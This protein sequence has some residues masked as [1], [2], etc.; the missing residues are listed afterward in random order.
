MVL[1]FR[2]DP[3]KGDVVIVANERAKRPEV[4]G[5]A[6]CPFCKGAENTT[7]PTTFALPSEGD[8]KVRTFRNLFAVLKP[9]GKFTPNEGGESFWRSQGVGD[10]EIIVETETHG[11]L[12]QEFSYD[13]LSMVFKAYKNR[14]VELSAREGVRCTFLFK[15]H[16]RLAGASID[17]EHSQIIALPFIPPIIQREIDRAEDHRQK[18]GDCL[19]CDLLSR[20]KENTLFENNSFTAICPSFSRFPFEIWI[21]PKE[22]KNTL[23][24]F[25][26]DEGLEF[27]RL[28]QDCVKALSKVSK[29]YNVVYH[30]APDGTDLHFHAEIYPRANVWAGIELGTGLLVNI[31]TE[32]EALAA[33]K[34][35]E[36]Y[37][38]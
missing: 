26:N 9:E 1:E 5:T 21:I 32:K 19:Y 2:E 8:W 28:L 37:G 31:K 4:F 7:P 13:E 22:H 10:H 29:D 15:N 34:K 30:S 6:L 3:S 36:D 24:E 16:G 12:L 27:M 23:A 14:Y 18:H 17:H 25:G 35:P 38:K 33:L 11:K 20:E